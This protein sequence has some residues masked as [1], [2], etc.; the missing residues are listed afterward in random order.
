M[1][2]VQAYFIRGRS[3][4]LSL[5]H[6]AF[7]LQ[8]KYVQVEAEMLGVIEGAHRVHFYLDEAQ[9]GAAQSDIND[10]QTKLLRNLAE[11]EEVGGGGFALE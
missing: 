6:Q 3:F 7:H 11:S 4:V 10:G 5:I 8:H 9:I 2:A 1:P